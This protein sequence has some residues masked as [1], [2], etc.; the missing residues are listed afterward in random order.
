MALI[1]G[2]QTMVNADSDFASQAEAEARSI[3][4]SVLLEAGLDVYKVRRGSA[5]AFSC[6]LM[7]FASYRTSHSNVPFELK[8]LL[9][10]C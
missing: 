7:S 1:V 4:E 8:S 2:Y 9:R 5:T 6:M 3:V 10:S